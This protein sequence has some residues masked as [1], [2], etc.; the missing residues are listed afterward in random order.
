MKAL[1]ALAALAT[2]VATGASAM[3]DSSANLAEIKR[4]APNADVSTLTDSEIASLL[5]GIHAGEDSDKARWVR[6][7]FLNK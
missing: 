2:V 6:S 3:I 7:F 4:Y 1:I 5:N